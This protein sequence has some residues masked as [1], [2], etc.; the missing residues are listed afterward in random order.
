MK[1]E[2]CQYTFV[3]ALGGLTVGGA[4]VLSLMYISEITPEKLI[5]TET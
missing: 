4:M 5:I 2:L 1:K 3:A